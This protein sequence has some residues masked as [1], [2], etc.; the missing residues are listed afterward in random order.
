M[1]TDVMEG[2]NVARGVAQNDDRFRADSEYDVIA[3]LRQLAGMRRQMP[4]G[5][6]HALQIQRVNLGRQVKLALQRLPPAP[7]AR[8]GFPRVKVIVHAA[9]SSRP[10]TLRRAAWR[11]RGDAVNA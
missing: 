4:L 11:A 2:A 7:R 9:P 6:N 3:G 1:A 5:E 10:L 8:R